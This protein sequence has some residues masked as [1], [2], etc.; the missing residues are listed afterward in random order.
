MD[1][2]IQNSEYKVSTAKLLPDRPS[3]LAS[4]F[5]CRLPIFPKSTSHSG[6]SHQHRHCASQGGHQIR[7][8]GGCGSLSLPPADN[9]LCPG[10]LTEQ[11]APG[12]GAVITPAREG[13]GRVPRRLD[14]GNYMFNPK[15]SDSEGKA[16]LP[17]VTQCKVLLTDT[18][19]FS[20]VK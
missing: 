17:E 10:D 2:F 11:G 5:L 6:N 1:S 3:F 14:R 9:H 18:S 19:R 7:V 8:P 4:S 13:E 15:L 16:E 12:R 20:D